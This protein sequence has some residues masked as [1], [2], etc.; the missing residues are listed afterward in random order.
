MEYTSISDSSSNT[1]TVQQPQTTSHQAPSALLHMQATGGDLPQC[2]QRVFDDQVEQGN[3][4]KQLF[5]QYLAHHGVM[6]AINAAISKLF[7]SSSLPS[8]PLQFIGHHMIQAS[9]AENVKDARFDGR[10]CETAPTSTAPEE[11]LMN[12][13]G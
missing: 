1:A 13:K 6:P 9:Q 7:S 8:D 3:K 11:E 4:K 12:H 10:N 2:P 5:Q